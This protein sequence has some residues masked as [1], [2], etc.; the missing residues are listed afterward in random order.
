MSM[1]RRMYKH[2]EHAGKRSEG[3]ASGIEG[4]ELDHPKVKHQSE[5]GRE[6]LAHHL[7]KRHKGR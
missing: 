3:I 4:E 7:S 1:E 2:K 5:H 6:R